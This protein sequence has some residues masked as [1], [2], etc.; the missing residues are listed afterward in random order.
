MPT[1]RG[2]AHRLLAY[3]LIALS[4]ATGVGLPNLDGTPP[5]LAAGL[6][7]TNGTRVVLLGTGTPGAEPDRSGPSTA[8]VVGGRA[9]LVDFG[10]RR[11]PTGLQSCIDQGDRAALCPQSGYR[12]P[13]PPPL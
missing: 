13:D 3:V 5:A 10:P 9:Y 8:V 11:G 12:I 6:Q 1:D 7:T 2:G 4:V